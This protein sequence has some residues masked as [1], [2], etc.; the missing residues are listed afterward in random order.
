MGSSKHLLWAASL[1]NVRESAAGATSGETDVTQA[2]Q[3]MIS[4]GGN[5]V[6]TGGKGVLVRNPYDDYEFKDMF[7]VIPTT[8]WSNDIFASSQLFPS[9]SGASDDWDVTKYNPDCPNAGTNGY[10]DT[11]GCKEDPGNPGEWGP[12]NYVGV[13]YV[14][15][16]AMEKI[17]YDF[18]HIQDDD[19]GWGVFYPT[20]SNSVD[21]R[22]RWLEDY[23]GYECGPGPAGE[24]GG[25]WIDGTTGV[26]NE[27]PDKIGTGGYPAGN[28]VVDDGNGG[29]TGCHLDKRGSLTLD[30]TDAWDSNGENLVSDHHCQ[31]NYVFSSNWKDWV[32]S[33]IQNA[34]SKPETA[35]ENWFAGGKAPSRAMDMAAC[36]VNNLRDMINLQNEIYWARQDWSNQLT[37]ATQWSKDPQ[38]TRIYWGWN[39]LP[40]DRLSVIDPANHDATMLKI[41][42]SLCGNGGGD[43]SLNCLSDGAAYALERDFDKWAKDGFL[44]PGIDNIRNR[45][46]SYVVLVREYVDDYYN[47]QKYFFCESWTS[48]NGNWQIVYLPMEETDS[49]TGA[50]YIQAGQSTLK[51]ASN[52]TIV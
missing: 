16:S 6:Y 9:T 21:W 28:P 42:A 34:A 11:I 8:F 44:V 19:W 27:A 36:W 41:P 17:F 15:G 26:W 5:G 47:W 45:P 4:R 43:D 23:N 10:F 35:Y 22:C 18:D 32:Y 39:E 3:S 38:S 29:G 49:G 46:G 51:T 20:D 48:P 13:T 24:H 1:S 31:C 40:M 50:C 25:G 14:I 2:L 33:W 37:P 12:W 30:Q 52:F 7:H